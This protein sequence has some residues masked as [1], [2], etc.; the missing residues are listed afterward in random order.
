M[1]HSRPLPSCTGLCV[2]PKFPLLQG[3]QSNRISTHPSGF[4][5][6]WLRPLR[7]Y[8][9]RRSHS[10]V[11][12]VGTS[13]SLFFGGGDGV[14]TIQPITGSSCSQAASKMSQAGYS[15]SGPVEEVRGRIIRI[16]SCL[17]LAL[18]SDSPRTEGSLH[19]PS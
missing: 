16:C 1:N 11:L 8:F 9:Q 10:E 17:L 13:T 4:I 5:F 6:T 19:A 12:G 18:F 2:M 14:D 7:L 15:I 3:H